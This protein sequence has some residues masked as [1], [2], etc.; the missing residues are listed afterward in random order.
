MLSL[1]GKMSGLL[2]LRLLCAVAML[3][4]LHVSYTHAEEI[5]QKDHFG[6][7]TGL[8][9]PRFV[10]LKG[11]KANMR[12]GPSKTHAI[13]WQ[14]NRKG[15]PVE[16]IDEFDH[17]RKVRDM[18]GSEGW[19]HQMVLSGRRTVVTLEG[20]HFVR[21]GPNYDYDIVAQISGGVILT[22]DDC[23]ESWCLLEHDT[24][25][26]WLPKDVLYGVYSSE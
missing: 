24:F 17:W 25:E 3:F 1:L 9:I 4:S 15:L 11:N 13:K 22:P 5:N 18:D 10:T 16:V 21:S 20:D 23:S 14:Y 8:P 12:F 7:I 26:G 6:R 2:R 19:I